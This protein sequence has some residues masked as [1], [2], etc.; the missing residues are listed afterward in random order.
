MVRASHKKREEIK[1]KRRRRRNDILKV[2][3]DV[4]RTLNPKKLLPWKEILSARPNTAMASV[5]LGILSFDTLYESSFT[6]H[7]LWNQQICRVRGLIETVS[8][9][10]PCQANQIIILTT[11]TGRTQTEKVPNA[12]KKKKKIWGSEERIKPETVKKNAAVGE[13]C[14]V[15]VLS[16]TSLKMWRWQCFFLFAFFHISCSC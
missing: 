7:F 13:R 12:Q 4:F 1:E 11:E 16:L 14:V 15:S 10:K 8:N 3:L 5:G 2:K 6:S 9:N